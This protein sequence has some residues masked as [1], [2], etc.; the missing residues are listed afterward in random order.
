MTTLALAKHGT[1]DDDRGA[2]VAASDYHLDRRTL[3]RNG[4]SSA[5]GLLAHA[6]DSLAEGA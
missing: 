5:S 2:A 4:D 3:T 1:A 6:L